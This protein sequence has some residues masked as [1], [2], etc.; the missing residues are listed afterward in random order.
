M[1]L[2]TGAT[3]FLGHNL[4]PL[5]VKRGQAVRVLARKSSQTDFLKDVEIAHGDVC[6]LESV[7]AAMKDCQAV[8]HGA[9]KFRFWGE[10]DEFF[11]IN[12][13]GTQN[14]LQAACEQGVH[15]FIH[16]STIAVIGKPVPGAVITEESIPDP[17]DAYQR[18]K[19]EGER[20]V[21]QCYETHKLPIIIL[22]PGA[23]YGPWGRYAFN[24]LFF[25]DPLKGLPIQVHRGKHINFPIFLP[26]LCRVIK[27]ALT[28]GRPGEIYNVSGQSLTHRQINQIVSR[29]AN[30]P[31]FVNAPGWG[32]I[33][34]A[35]LWTF[36]SNFTRRE[37]YYPI[38]L[39]PY[40]FF[41]WV[42]SSDKARRELAFEPT[43]FEEG[44]R[45]TLEWYWSQG[46][47][48]RRK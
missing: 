4:V 23:F 11:K 37:P 34:L 18:S 39:A 41:D 25:E 12:V 30:L 31:L 24:R 48:E 40:V 21:R 33:A 29:L 7:R 45:Q 5:L 27:S 8:I 14:V 36:L 22:R 2:V 1:I 38:N 43:L 15:R 32:M 47:F 16:I 44:A 17:Q 3:G 26:D 35:R 28:F 10:E 42:V 20:V 46:I 9:G 6:D 13:G 19:L